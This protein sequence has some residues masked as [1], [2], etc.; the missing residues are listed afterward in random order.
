MTGL[1][2]TKSWALR[3][4][5]SLYPKNDT[6]AIDTVDL[7]TSVNWGNKGT[8]PVLQCYLYLQSA[9]AP[10]VLNVKSLKSRWMRTQSKVGLNDKRSKNIS[11]VLQSAT[12][13]GCF[14]EWSSRT[15]LNEEF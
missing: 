7:K 2:E 14:H 13:M 3:F 15:L 4:P 9:G 5:A 12:H 8:S 1:R 10:G 11:T 6:E